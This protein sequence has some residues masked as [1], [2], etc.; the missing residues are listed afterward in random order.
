MS[1]ENIPHAS[2]ESQPQTCP[3]CN[4]RGWKDN[5]CPTS[6]QSIVCMACNGRGTTA[7]GAVCGGCHGTGQ[8]ETRLQDKMPCPLCNGAGIYPIPSSMNEA[9]FAFRPR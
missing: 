7:S 8:I 1:P 2:P 3:E 5:R 9:E 4:G 6:D